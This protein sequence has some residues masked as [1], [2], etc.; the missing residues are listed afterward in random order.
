VI[1]RLYNLP[2]RLLLAG[3]FVFVGLMAGV[4]ALSMFF[5]NG[6]PICSLSVAM[7]LLLFGL[8]VGALVLFNERGS[9]SRAQRYRLKIEEAIKKLEAQ[10]D[11]DSETYLAR[12]AFQIEECEDEGSHYFIELENGGV[13]FLSGQYLYDYEPIEKKKGII[14]PRR[15]PATQFTV[16]RHKA[17]RYVPDIVCEGAVLEPEV[18]APA[19]ATDDFGSDRIPSDGQVIKT[20]NYDQLKAERLKGS[21]HGIEGRYF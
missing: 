21:S 5:P 2:M 8:I 9:P 4:V 3:L 7:V 19:F 13:L 10:N 11:L 16:R 15:F 18:L 20:Q 12:R 14:Q 6:H 1:R 17:L